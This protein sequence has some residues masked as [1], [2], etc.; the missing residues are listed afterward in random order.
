MATHELRG[1]VLYRISLDDD[2]ISQWAFLFSVGQQTK[3][4]HELTYYWFTQTL[5]QNEQR[6]IDLPP[7]GVHPLLWAVAARNGGAADRFSFRR[8]ILG[9]ADKALLKE[10]D[11]DLSHDEV[12]KTNLAH[13]RLKLADDRLTFQMGF[14]AQLRGLGMLQS[15][16]IR[17]RYRTVRGA[18]FKIGDPWKIPP[19][20]DHWNWVFNGKTK[21]FR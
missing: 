1:H 6:Q 21:T 5:P 12:P 15:T 17:G 18:P 11:G 16:K 7:S 13:V 19:K 4:W 8:S 2:S 14:D 3:T 10:A 20:V 9:N